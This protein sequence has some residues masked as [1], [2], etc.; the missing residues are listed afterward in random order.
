MASLRQAARRAEHG[1]GEQTVAMR[2]AMQ[3]ALLVVVLSLVVWAG[4]T[5][6]NPQS[7]PLRTV[8]ITT[9]LVHVSQ[10]E[11]SGAV[12]QYAAAGF[13][14]VD[15]AGMREQL[16]AIAWVYQ[17]SLRRV[18][19]DVIEVGVAEQVPVAHWDKGGLVNEHGEVF[20]PSNEALPLHLPHFAGPEGTGK[21]IVEYHR[22]LRDVVA[23]I[24]LQ[25]QRIELSER[26]AW[27]IELDNGLQLALGRTDTYPRMQR[28][29]KSYAQSIAP[30]LMEIEW[31]DLR[32]TNGF[33][34]RRRD[35]H[36]PSA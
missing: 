22:Q 2:W 32:Y 1:S 9:P 19:P 25:V 5:L 10:Q 15:M 34:I 29:V 12:A 8:R 14:R 13:V 11:I 31:I 27:N 3:G 4:W 30:R 18:W 36:A 21:T 16:E 7:F 35:G 33:A 6:W 23:P 20:T 17:I 24:G 28:F 26:R